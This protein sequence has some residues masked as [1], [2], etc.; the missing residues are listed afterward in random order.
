MKVRA[1]CKPMCDSC[2]LII[3]KRKRRI[4]CAKF[5]KHKQVQG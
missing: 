4:V 2:R 3:R 1:S 5:P